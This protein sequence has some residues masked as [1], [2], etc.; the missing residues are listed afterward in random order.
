MTTTT[1]GLRDITAADSTLSF[2]E[3]AEGKLSY[4]GYTIEDLAANSSFEECVALLWDRDL[5]ARARLDELTH[6]LQEAAQ[7]DPAILAAIAA[8]PHSAHPMA[9]LRTAVSM[10]AMMD[11]EADDPS[12]EA[13]ER[14]AIRLVARTPTVA[15]MS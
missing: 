4:C 3:G 9:A 12:M 10:L 11:E 13:N 5:P 15:E 6:Q 7:L 2:V 14:K 8:F 1:A